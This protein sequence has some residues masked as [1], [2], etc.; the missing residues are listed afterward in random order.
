LGLSAIIGDLGRMERTPEISVIVPNLNEERFLPK[1]LKSLQNQ[2][3]KD[4]ELIVIDGGSVDDSLY[5]LEAWMKQLDLVIAIDKTPNLGYVR[6][7]ASLLARGKIM[8]HT[9]SDIM[10]DPGLLLKIHEKMQDQHIIS[11]TGRTKPIG[12]K[13]LPHLAYQGFDFVRFLFSKLP[14]KLRKYRPS[15]NFLVIRSHV[16]RH[17]GGFPELNCNEDGIL[18]QFIDDF[19]NKFPWN[20]VVFDLGLYVH[21]HHKRFEEKGSI[22]TILFYFYVLRNMFPQLGFLLSPIERRSGEAFRTRNDLKDYAGRR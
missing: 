8:F 22:Q 5:I 20:R 4:F 19:I 16:F 18:G 10:M 21:H 9:N 12:S 17:I 13:I 2:S 14:E 11:L 1:F 3:F 15:G 6:N 7:I